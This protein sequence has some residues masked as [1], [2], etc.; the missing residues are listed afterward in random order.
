MKLGLRLIP[1]FENTF[2][3]MET[4]IAALPLGI[5]VMLVSAMRMYETLFRSAK[6]PSSIPL[7]LRG[8]DPSSERKRM[9]KQ[10]RVPKARREWGWGGGA[11]KAQLPLITS[12]KFI[13]LLLCYGNFEL[14]HE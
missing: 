2:I 7:L 12:M 1:L 13:P 5:S 11:E 14:S 9:K 3:F 6:A 10:L 4:D 8:L